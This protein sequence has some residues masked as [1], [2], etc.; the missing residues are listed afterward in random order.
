MKS[1]QPLFVELY[2]FRQEAPLAPRRR[3]GIR[4]EEVNEDRKKYD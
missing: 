2:R 3:I 4:R 1:S